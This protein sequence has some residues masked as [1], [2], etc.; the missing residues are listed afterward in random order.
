MEDGT[1]LP[2]FPTRRVRILLLVSDTDRRSFLADT[3]PH[4]GDAETHAH[5]CKPPRRRKR[6][7][8]ADSKLSSKTNGRALNAFA[9]ATPNEEEREKERKE[10]GNGM[11]LVRPQSAG[12]RRG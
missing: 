4:R 12:A 6:I 8:G 5:I 1:L 11:T 7:R 3:E 9:E 10:Q 2:R